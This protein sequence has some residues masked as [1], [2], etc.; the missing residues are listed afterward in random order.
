MAALA[1]LTLGQPAHAQSAAAPA[2]GGGGNVTLDFANAEIDAVARTMATITGR[3]VV[4][5]PRVKGTMTLTSTAPVSPSQ[6]MRLFSVQ[7]RTQGFALVESSGMYIV[8][9]E[10]EAK[11]QSSTVSA[12]S[13]RAAS[14]QIVTQIFRLT[15]ENANNLVPVLRPLISPNNT[16]NVNPGTNALIITDYADNLQRLARIIAALDVSNATG[17]EIVR[18]KHAVASDLAPLVSRLLESGSGGM[19]MGQPMPGQP[20][21]APAAMG[22]G[23]DGYRTTLV[24]EPR[25]NAIIVRA[26]NPARLALAKTLIQQLDQAPVERTDGGSGNIHVVYLKNADAAKLA[27]TLRAAL[28]AL[29]GQSNTPGGAGTGG[30]APGTGGMMA[31]P[32]T[33]GMSSSSGMGGS[34]NSLATGPSINAAANNQPSTGGQIQADPAT[35]SLIISAPEP[36]YREL[37]AVIDKLDQRRAQVF[38]ESLIAEVRAEKAAEFGIQWQGVLGKKG[39]TNIGVL[40]TNY[41]GS[42]SSNIIDFASQFVGAGKSGWKPSVPP[43]EG[44]NFG[45]AHKFGGIYALSALANFLQSSGSGNVLSTPTLL[46]LDNEEAKIIVGQNVPFITGSFT[47]TGAASTTVNPFQTYERQDVGLT[48][49]VRP[50][51]SE[52]GTVKMVIYQETSNLVES[53]AAGPITRKRAIESSVLVDDGAIVV[54][55]GLLEDQYGSSV[56]KV[57]LLGDVPVLGNL[58]KSE[59]RK[60]VKTNLMVFL[61]PVIVR[62]AAA[63]ENYSLDRYDLMRA[64]QQNNQP[65]PSTVLQI[66]EAPVMPPVI[67]ANPDAWTRPA[68][69]P[70]LISL[71]ASGEGNYY[72][73]TTINTQ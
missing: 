36:V 20:G 44:F 42:G 48:L 14:G 27:V 72:S 22:L 11:L 47:N 49:R 2:A 13:P 33:Q 71:P 52:D 30:A 6:A 56:D 50:Q 45:L 32:V 1:V 24:P 25:S 62:D 51:I 59:N 60:L 18:L 21:M 26:A 73:G 41:R 16:I 57:P 17:V 31:T 58:F 37:R 67:P 55:G 4:V 65:A 69:P 40:G 35:N 63:T 39:D 29:P 64:T 15:H 34:S 28:A 3:N 5:D 53:T 19:P 8:L 46:T 10:A 66:N 38:I 23:S 61:R 68:P 54:L 12:G 9:P 7:L 70:P 43:S